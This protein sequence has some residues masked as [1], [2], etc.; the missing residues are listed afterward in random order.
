MNP[1]ITSFG[2]GQ[3]Y[4]KGIER[5]KNSC[6]EFNVIC[7]PFLN[8]PYGCPTH[9]DIPYAFKPYC[10]DAVRKYHD[11]VLWADAS[12]WIINDP[13]P[14]FEIIHDQGYIIFDSGW[15]NDQWCSNRQLEAFGFNRDQAADQRQVV[16]GLFGIDFSTDLGAAI[17][18]IY[19]NSI[20]LFKGQWTNEHLTESADPRCL[21]CRHDQ[22]ILSLIAATLDLTITNPTGYFTFDPKQKDCIFALQGM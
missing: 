3:W 14:I 17:F 7:Q 19:K 1:V 8:Y 15:K 22:S 2:K 9:Q 21:G 6:N 20:D 4:P 16:G 13:Q 11:I 10:M 12:A 5:L 18:E